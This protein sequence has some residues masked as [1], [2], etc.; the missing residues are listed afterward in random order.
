MGEEYKKALTGKTLWV[1]FNSFTFT[2]LE[3]QHPPGLAL[4]AIFNLIQAG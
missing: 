1:E 2:A 3:L 4:M